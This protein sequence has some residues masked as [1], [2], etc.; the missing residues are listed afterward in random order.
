[1]KKSII[2]ILLFG[3]LSSN[4]SA[5]S[6]LFFEQ[7]PEVIAPEPSVCSVFWWD[8]AFQKTYSSPAS[9]SNGTSVRYGIG[10]RPDEQHDEHLSF[11]LVCKEDDKLVS[12]PVH[13]GKTVSARSLVL[14]GTERKMIVDDIQ[15]IR[16]KIVETSTSNKADRIALASLIPTD[17]IIE[18]RK[19]IQTTQSDAELFDAEKKVLDEALKNLDFKQL[20]TDVFFTVERVLQAYIDDQRRTANTGSRPAKAKPAPKKKP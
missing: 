10:V 2:G 6:Y 8:D 18:V 17:Q 5:Q 9:F 16:H 11:S 3:I 19:K 20:K 13:D 4:A 7:D 1:M 12:V 14:R 15:D